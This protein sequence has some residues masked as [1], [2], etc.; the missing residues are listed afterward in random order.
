MIKGYHHFQICPPINAVP[1]VFL[2][3]QPEYCNYHDR[4]ACLVLLPPLKALPKKQHRIATD[5]NGNYCIEDIAELPIGMVPKGLA[6][7]FRDLMKEFD[8]QVS[9]LPTGVPQKSSPPWP[10]WQAKG[11]E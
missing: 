11:M 4:N 6:G 7:M 2:D 3:V 10:E 1:P 9:A 5:K 8:G